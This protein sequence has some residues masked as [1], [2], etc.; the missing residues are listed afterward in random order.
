MEKETKENVEKTTPEQ[1]NNFISD[2]EKE[3]FKELVSQLHMKNKNLGR[4]SKI[5]HYCIIPFLCL[6]IIGAGDTVLA[7]TSYSGDPV[8]LV[9]CILSI[10]TMI[11]AFVMI[12]KLQSKSKGDI[13]KIYKIM[14]TKEFIDLSKADKRLL[15]SFL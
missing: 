3:E 10:V 5:A 4:Y 7:H 11:Y 6:L 15:K 9:I 13:N 2:K 14:S 8:N 12:V 1:E